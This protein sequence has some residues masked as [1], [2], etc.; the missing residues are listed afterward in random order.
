LRKE[1]GREWSNEG[2]YLFG[3]GEM[4]AFCQETSRKGGEELAVKLRTA[5]GTQ[6]FKPKDWGKLPSQGKIHKGL[7]ET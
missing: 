3:E 7:R 1:G 6:N 5:G 2:K 4:L